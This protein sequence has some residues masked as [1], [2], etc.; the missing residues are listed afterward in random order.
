MIAT[1]VSGVG[2]PAEANLLRAKGPVRV[3]VVARREGGDH[4]GRLGLPEELAEDRADRLDGLLQPG[5]GHRR[6]PVPQAAQGAEVGAGQSR[7]VEQQVDQGRRQEGVGDAVPPGE[8][9]ELPQVGRRHDDDLA[10]QR[11]D[12]EAQ[13]A[14]PRA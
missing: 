13:D 2:R 7:V 5:G 9:E 12:R 1:V 6:G 3:Q 10:A 8:R 11:H 14:R 4:H